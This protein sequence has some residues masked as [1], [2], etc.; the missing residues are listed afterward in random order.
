MGKNK[1][2]KK[3]A[4]GKKE[5]QQAGRVIKIL[6]ATLVGLGLLLIISFSFL[7]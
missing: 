5:E 4:R 7:S 3:N 1:S 2:K 6:F